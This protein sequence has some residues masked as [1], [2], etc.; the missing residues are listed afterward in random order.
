MESDGGKNK[1]MRIWIQNGRWVSL[2]R[3][4]NIFLIHFSQQPVVP[5]KKSGSGLGLNIIYNLVKE[6]LQDRSD[7]KAR[8]T[9]RAS[10]SCWKSVP[11][12]KGSVNR[13]RGV[14]MS[15]IN[16]DKI[17]DEFFLNLK[18]TKQH[19]RK[20][21]HGTLPIK[22]MAEW[23]PGSASSNR[24]DFKGLPLRNSHWNNQHILCCRNNWN[25]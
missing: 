13:R 14:I 7:A 12:T 6:N 9:R 17:N 11:T 3:T 24:N 25:I 18:G 1:F 5:V 22:L 21:E 8:R 23:W 2:K 15:K 20:R 4:W 19:L 16:I 10:C